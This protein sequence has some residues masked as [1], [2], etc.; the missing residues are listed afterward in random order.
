MEFRSDVIT[1]SGKYS[2]NQQKLFS[3]G[4]AGFRTKADDLET[5]LF[6]MGLLAALR[7]KAKKAHIGLMITASHNPACDNGVKLVD[8]YGEM[9]VESWEAHATHV[10]NASDD[11]L[12]GVLHCIVT[13]EHITADHTAQVVIGRDTRPSSNTLHAAAV[14]GVEALGGKV[15]DCGVVTTPLLHYRVRCANDPSYGVAS[16]EGYTDKLVETF[17]KL[18]SCAQPATSCAQPATSCYCQDLLFDG[19]NGVGGLQ[20]AIMAPRISQALKLTIHNGGEGQGVLN[21]R[22]G[23]DFVKVRE[24][25]EGE[26]DG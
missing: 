8:P 14:S 12:A 18:Q 17:L 7:S 6:R 23:A 3:Y 21:Y 26:S 1:C 9:M 10:A 20:M 13:E 15:V 25:G 19:A 24:T 22:C 16:N 2:N 4:T 11:E 5:V